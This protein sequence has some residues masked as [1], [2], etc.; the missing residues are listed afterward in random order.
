M[1]QSDDDFEWAKVSFF[2]FCFFQPM[3]IK[4]QTEIEKAVFLFYSD[5]SFNEYIDLFER[6]NR[7]NLN[8]SYSFNQ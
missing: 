2:N 5:L 4:Q 7:E 3:K 6:G 8:L 1:E